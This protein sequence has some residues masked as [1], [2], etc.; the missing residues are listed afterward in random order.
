MFFRLC[1]I[2]AT[3][4]VADF[5]PGTSSLI[6]DILDFLSVRRLV[7]DLKPKRV[8]VPLHVDTQ[9]NLQDRRASLA[10]REFHPKSDDFANTVV[11]ED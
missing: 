7:G 11:G 10:P 9:G 5:F 2:G 3:R 4:Y 6:P 8:T 1:F